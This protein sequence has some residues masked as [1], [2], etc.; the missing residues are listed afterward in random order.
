MG[1]VSC[2]FLISVFPRILGV[3]GFN[4]FLLILMTELTPFSSSR[5]FYFPRDC[6]QWLNETNGV[7]N[8]NSFRSNCEPSDS[9]LICV[10]QHSME[11]LSEFPQ[12]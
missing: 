9:F 10:C 1:N 5:I 8:L 3:V 11:E 6:A 7:F 4:V 12:A 2:T